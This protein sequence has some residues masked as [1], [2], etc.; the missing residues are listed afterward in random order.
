VHRTDPFEGCCGEWNAAPEDKEIPMSTHDQASVVAAC[1]RRSFELAP[2]NPGLSHAKLLD[3]AA[4]EMGYAHFTD[5]RRGLKGSVVAPNRNVRL[6]DA[7]IREAIAV[8]RTSLPHFHE[9][10]DCIRI[11]YEWLD[12]QCRTKGRIRSTLP[13]K[14][15]I[16]RWA[17]RYVSQTDV[18]VAAFMHPAI[19]GKYPYFNISS[20][21]TRPN[22]TRLEDIPEAFK[23]DYREDFE[24]RTYKRREA[25]QAAA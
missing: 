6:T 9:H 19:C 14:H 4:Q 23:H 18:E 15:I 10:L 25:A 5:L 8:C 20:Q 24:S 13:I 16:E 7:Q 11:A 2:A 22:E 17:G 1:K 3:K 12:A 21:L